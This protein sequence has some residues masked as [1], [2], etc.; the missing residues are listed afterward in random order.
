MDRK[1]LFLHAKLLQFDLTISS[2]HSNCSRS[3]LARRWVNQSRCWPGWDTTS[4][5]SLG[6]CPGTQDSRTVSGSDPEGLGSRCLLAACLSVGAR[7]LDRRAGDF[8]HRAGDLDDRRDRD[9]DRRV[10]DCDC[11][12]GDLDRRALALGRRVFALDF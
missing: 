10:R 7:A 2:I 8:D 11:R 3:L 12:A 9:L 5:C 6:G 1:L 4:S